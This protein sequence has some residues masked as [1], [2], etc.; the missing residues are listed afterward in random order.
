[1][2]SNIKNQKKESLL[3]NKKWL[4]D[5]EVI[6]DYEC[7]IELFWYEVKSIRNKNFNLKWS[8]ISINNN[9]LFIQK[10]HI[11]LYKFY[12]NSQAYDP[13]RERK[14]FLHKKDVEYLQTKLKEKWFTIIPI[15]VYLKWNLI[16]IKIWLVRWKKLYEKKQILKNKDIEFDIK[17]SLSERT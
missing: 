15:E 11:S 6:K 5:Y 8:F 10:M 9:W 12:S 3:V 1:M 13:E 17:R 16:K 4:N 14:L 7:S 2:S